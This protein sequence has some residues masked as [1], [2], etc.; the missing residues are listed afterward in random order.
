[1][2]EGRGFEDAANA[3]NDFVFD[4]Y[5]IVCGNIALVSR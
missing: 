1:M 4:K 2:T 5:G 3:W